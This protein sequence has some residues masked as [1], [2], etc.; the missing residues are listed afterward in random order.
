MVKFL[1]RHPS[2]SPA[3]VHLANLTTLFQCCLGM[4]NVPGNLCGQGGMSVGGGGG[5]TTRA[6]VSCIMVLHNDYA[7]DVLQF[8]PCVRQGRYE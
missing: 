8:L 2:D 6:I 5:V 4:T 1:N 7:H 3:F